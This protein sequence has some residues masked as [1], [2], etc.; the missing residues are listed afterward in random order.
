MTEAALRRTR[1]GGEGRSHRALEK[2]LIFSPHET[3]SHR[4]GFEH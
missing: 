3:A 2:T 4:W 1:G